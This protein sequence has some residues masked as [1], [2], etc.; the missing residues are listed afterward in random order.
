MEERSSSLT[1]IDRL[2]NYFLRN[3]EIEKILS[4]IDDY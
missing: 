4:F 1:I 2:N 3:S